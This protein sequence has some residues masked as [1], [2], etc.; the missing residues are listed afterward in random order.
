MHSQ[1]IKVVDLVIVSF[2]RFRCLLF[3]SFLL[4]SGYLHAQ[5]AD[6]LA[7]F[8][9]KGKTLSNAGKAIPNVTLEL[10]RNDSLVSKFLSGKTGK[11]YIEIEMALNEKNK[12]YVLYV[13]KEGMI[14]K[15]LN[16]NTQIPKQE[17]LSY[18]YDQYD[19]YL[20]IIMLNKS[21]ADKLVT[22]HS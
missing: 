5:E 13:S 18:T 15:T 20:E 16:I 7:I 2:F 10:R 3:S 8:I 14:P 12:E 17:F 9:L 6:T 22:I 19:F 11:F 1:F 4:T 21:N